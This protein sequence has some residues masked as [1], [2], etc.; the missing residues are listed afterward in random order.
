MSLTVRVLVG[1]V[2]GFLIGLVAPASVAAVLAPVGALF[3]N[4]IRVT[5]FPLVV[6]MLVASIGAIASSRA[7]G[8]AGV[9]AIV[10]AVTL[11]AVAAT[12]SALV[13][14]PV[15]ARVQIDRAA[16]QALQPSAP[17][18]PS[19]HPAPAGDSRAAQWLVDLVPANVFR[20]VADD[21]MLPVVVFAVLFALALAR[22]RDER[23]TPVLHVV[24]G[25]AEAMQRLVS[26]IL[27]LAP[28]GV[29]ALAVPLAARLGV[30]AAGAVA[31][32][33]VLVVSLTVVA[34]LVLLYPLGSVGGRMTPGAF[35]SF[36]A[37]AQAVA[38]SS[39]SSLAALPAMIETAE[40]SGV[41]PVVAGFIV[42]LA[43]SVFRF[44]AAIAQTVG[45][46]FLA[47]LYG[48]TLSPSQLASVVVAVVFTTFAVP[49]IPGGSIIAMVPV[50]RAAD[51]PVDGIGI[52][53][54]VDAIPDMFR[55]T[56]N[57]TGTLAVAAAL[58]IRRE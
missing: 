2:A 26:A 31:A 32:Y 53:L 40:Q 51:V 8:R 9:R 35:A 58:S 28:Y 48:V 30:A 5:V 29:F 14:A 44:G 11:L 25:I 15:L 6:S 46:L 45:V 27:D 55:T 19:A 7:L 37:P 57:V 41:P 42:P 49:G 38:F 39:R 56:A 33:I 4:L 18:A 21:A 10:M 47:R 22:V 43:A 12:A 3:I 17:T 24:E 20:S 1:L 54:A 50:L 34:S 16:A 36:C 52:L 23:R 13:A